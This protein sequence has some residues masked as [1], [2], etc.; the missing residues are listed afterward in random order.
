MPWWDLYRKFRSSLDSGP[1]ETTEI[2]KSSGAGFLNPEAIADLRATG[3][4]GE[5]TK[6][7][8]TSEMVDTSAITSRINRYK[9]YERIRA[10]P[11]IESTMT[12]LSQEACIAGDTLIATPFHGKKTIKWLKDNLSGEKFFVY[13]YDF[14]KRDYTIGIAFDPRV[15]KK[16]KTIIIALDDGT[17]FKCTTDH[18]LLMLDKT[19]K[20]AGDVVRGDELMPFYRIDARPDLSGCKHHQYPRIRTDSYGW[21]NERQFIDIWR[22]EEPNPELQKFFNISRAITN[23]FGQAEIE[24]TY[25][26]YAEAVRISLKKFGTSRKEM[27]FLAEKKDRKKVLAITEGP[28]EEVYD[29][30]V[31]DHENF[32]GESIVFHNCQ[33][34]E[35]GHVFEIKVKNDKIQKELDWLFFHRKMLN[36]DCEMWPIV[37]KTFI[38]GDYFAELLVNPE[39]LEDGILGLAERPPESMFRI[40]TTKGRLLE[41]QQSPDGPDYDA[42]M[43]HPIETALDEELENGK[44][45][46]FAPEQIV[47]IRLGEG[48]TAFYPYGQSLIEPAR[49]PAH[50]LRMMEDGMLVYRLSRAP[51][52]RVFYIDTGSAPSHKIDMMI[53]RLKSRLIKKKLAKPSQGGSSAIEERFSA[54]AVD[55]DIWIPLRPNSQ[56]RIDTLP[57][58]QALGEVDDVLYFRNRVFQSLM[59]PQNYFN[60]DDPGVTRLTA[61]AQNVKL[62][63]MLERLQQPFEQALYEIAER[64]LRLMGVPESDYQDLQIKMTPP[65]DWREMIKQE[66]LSNRINNASS[67]KSAMIMSDFDLLT[68]ILKYPEEKAKEIEDRNTWQKLRDLK[69]NIVAQNP[70]LAGVGMPGDNEPQIGTEPGGPSPMLSPDGLPGLPG[71]TPGNAPQPEGGQLSNDGGMQQDQQP[72]M[73]QGIEFSM[74][75]QQSAQPQQDQQPKQGEDQGGA[76]M[77]QDPTPEEI[78]KYDMEIKSYRQDQDWEDID[79]SYM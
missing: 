77:L 44:C 51:E 73:D 24:S 67:L 56:T 54:P 78:E 9:E 3:G 37:K 34:G 20:A 29:L 70:R 32:C 26:Y 15:V 11:E 7:R 17:S 23:G 50:Q 59:F 53:E 74:D 58:A 52:R 27:K 10:V 42:P 36:M 12:V 43:K 69:L 6:L 41:F 19:W 25:G 1:I 13:C 64:H 22:L 4:Y 16:E 33:R 71:Q 2:T 45:I 31:Q 21:I 57:G 61:S 72:S 18:R 76:T 75:Q 5:Y 60:N 66:L 39:R 62:A 38:Q 35:N 55:E 28:I 79:F 14:E 63:Q 68:E 65:S 30:S 48:R 40:E 46:R 47:H 49:G 8:E